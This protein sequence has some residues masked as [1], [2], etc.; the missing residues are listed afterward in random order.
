MLRVDVDIFSGRPNPAWVVSDEDA[1]GAL[2]EEIAAVA[3]EAVGLSG[4][5][6]GGLGYREVVISSMSDDESWPDS[7]PRTFTLGTI[8]APDPRRSAEL[9]RRIVADMP[10]Y[11]AFKLPGHAE[12][13]LDDTTRD[14]VLEQMDRF[15]QDP[16][17]WFR[18]PLFPS[19]SLRSTIREDEPI[20]AGCFYEVSEFNPDFWNRPEVQPYNNCYN[21]ARNYR[22]DTFA[23]PGRA[24]GA[25]TDVMACPD[26][27]QAALADGLVR[28]F[29]C[30]PDS[31]YPR[32][33]MALVIWPGVDYHWYR[34]Q[35]GDFWGHKPGST[36]ARNYDNRGALITDP[37]TCDRGGYTDFCGYFYAGKSVVIN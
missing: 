31:E 15:F 2:L 27:T 30:L 7:L 12:T 28:R 29:D 19:N 33:L 9:A 21:Y 32:R 5:G 22:T 8:G 6:Y 24:H 25:Q 3:D 14:L 37:E 34:E 23:Q 26:V 13:P 17:E 36:A 20:D 10:R 1:A 18:P 11:R 4:A 35:R 16:P